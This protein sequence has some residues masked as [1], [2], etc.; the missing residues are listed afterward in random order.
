[1]GFSASESETKVEALTS[2][3]ARNYRHA[4]FW[5]SSR[6]VRWRLFEAVKVFQENDPGISELYQEKAFF[7]V[8]FRRES[9]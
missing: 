2:K 9:N 8:L 3:N 1:M 4:Q 5:S 7:S 6:S